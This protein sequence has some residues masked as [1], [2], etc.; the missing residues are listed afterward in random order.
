MADAGKVPL[1]L[2]LSTSVP[3]GIRAYRR[4]FLSPCTNLQTAGPDDYVNIYPDTS[5]PGSFIDPESTY[6][7]F[8]FQITNTHFCVDYTDFGVEGVGGAIIQ[9]WRVYNQGSILEE[10]LEYGTV[11]SALANIE[12][13]YEHEV[14]MYFSAKLKKGFQEEMH[15][16]F[17]K[18]PMVDNTGNIM[19]GPNPYGFGLDL[20]GGGSQYGNQYQ[21]GGT[22]GSTGQQ[23]AAGQLI[24]NQG[25]SNIS[26]VNGANTVISSFG[27]AGTGAAVSTFP[28]INTQCLNTAPS[29]SG[30]SGLAISAVTPMDFPDCF[31][32]SM[33]NIVKQYTAEFGTIN[34]PQVMANLCNVKCFPIGC[35]PAT[36]AFGDGA[37]GTPS[38]S[39]YISGGAGMTTAQ[40]TTAI[41]TPYK[42]PTPSNPTYR[43]C[44]RPYSGIFGKMA[45]KMLATTL[46]APQQLYINLHLA[47]AHIALNVSADP[48]RRISGTIRDYIRNV[49]TANSQLYGDVTYELTDNSG[50]PYVFTSS[51]Y[52]PGYGPFHSVPIT[53]GSTSI[54]TSASTIFSEA[55]AAGRINVISN[56]NMT[57]PA[58]LGTDALARN[59]N[60][61]PLPATP[62]Y[63]LT[64]APNTYK[65][66]QNGSGPAIKYAS[67]NEVFYG[68]YLSA[69]VPQSAR[70]FALTSEGASSTQA[71]ASGAI[72]YNLKNI[73]LVGDQLIL[74]NEVTA[75]II[76]QAE[77]GNF[78]V[79]TNSVRTYNLQIQNSETQSI[80]CPLKVNMAKRILFAFQNNKQRLASTGMIYDSN[81]GL[82]PFAAIHAVGN[83][84]AVIPSNTDTVTDPSGWN[85]V[86]RTNLY[87]VGYTTPLTYRPT[88]CSVGA[89]N[90]QVQL[91]IGND[92]YPPQPLTTMQEISAE[93]CKTLEGWQNSTFSPEIDGQ[94]FAASGA[95][96]TTGL[97]YDCLQPSKFVT[98]FVDAE[99]L[100]DQTITGNTDFVPLYTAFG[101]GV[102]NLAA[103]GIYNAGATR[104]APTNGYNYLCPRGYCT[105][106]L[107]KTPSSRFLLGFNMRAF[108]SSDGCDGGTYLGNNTITLI[109]N[110]A[111]GLAVPGES[112][113][114]IA[115]V[116]HRVAMRYSPGGQIIWAY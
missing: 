54:T 12:G 78:N 103:G 97:Y 109:M 89:S 68:T 73:N 94:M 20:I 112:Y 80:I 76:T 35:I 3:L 114:A 56:L 21:A 69:S 81:C 98:A 65:L 111:V 51:A 113:R 66:I 33:V 71:S 88:P 7:M 2:Q 57:G 91:R 101:L 60:F 63:A 27:T 64:K 8:D 86:G 28:F 79:H 72:T 115:I 58:A 4:R 106:G 67:E 52:A 95:N 53:K 46:L 61:V 104:N 74:P 13:S 48:C 39:A 31:S 90:I 14:F 41:G 84:K 11:A 9:D 110:G 83:T 49:G 96:P 32:P 108:K 15:Q 40:V 82:N 26:Q 25:T 102:S 10:I 100:D 30:S 1:D 24:G 99:L 92:F 47:S 5:T 29:W 116:P 85:S 105:N 107:F 87:G 22:A 93:L 16:N 34:K 43:V 17:I 50:N 38:A 59:V 75:D 77:A 23:Y 6:L 70:I 18:P 44:Y 37:Y 62:Q 42:T 45:T 55:A 36:S 19:F